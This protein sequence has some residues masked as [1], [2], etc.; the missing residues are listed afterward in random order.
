MVSPAS[1]SPHL[2]VTVNSRWA[3][4]APTINGI[5]SGGEWAGATVV[6]FIFKMRYGSGS[7]FENYSARFYVEN[8]YTNLYAAVQ[9]FGA[10]FHNEDISG[11]YDT[12]GLLFDNN[13]TGTL[14]SGD[15]GEGVITWSGSPYFTQNSWYYNGTTNS[16]V[17]DVSAHK[18]NVGALAWSHTNP[19]QGQIGNYTFEMMIPLVGPDLGYDFNIKTL[20]KTVG[21]KLWF[22]DGVDSANGV[23]P[24][25]TTIANS[26][27]QTKNAATFG[28]LILHPLYALT[29]TTTPPGGGTTTPAP[30]QHL[31]G[32]NETA[33]VTAIP[34]GGYAFDHWVLDTIP[35]G[36]VNPYSVTM[37]SNHT[38]E[39][40]FVPVVVVGG[41]AAPIMIPVGE[42]NLLVPLIWLT[43]VIVCSVASAVLFVKLKKKKL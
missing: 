20:P 25:N 24:D 39:A 18:T 36:S 5:I 31:Y 29:I 21:F 41:M 12:L 38:L 23:Y 19:I 43:S 3:H 26:L 32:W 4:T 16:W 30:G 27:L 17:S 8:D 28:D 13:D 2:G 42:A 37:M 40:V 34:N 22:R 10:P 11:Y 15:T 9:I 14:R 6:N 33:T 35:V 1:A 7:S